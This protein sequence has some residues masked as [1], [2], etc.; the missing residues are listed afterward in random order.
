MRIGGDVGAIVEVAMA[1]IEIEAVDLSVVTGH[2][3]E[4]AIA[5]DIAQDD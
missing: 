4:V 5:V 1:I 3:V 2:Q